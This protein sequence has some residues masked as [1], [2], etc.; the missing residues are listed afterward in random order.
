[1]SGK[2]DFSGRVGR[3]ARAAAPLGF[4]VCRN[5]S[6]YPQVHRRDWWSWRPGPVHY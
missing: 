2:S 6:G 3:A 4:R 5:R 1:M